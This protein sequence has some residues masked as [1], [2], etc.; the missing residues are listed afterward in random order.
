MNCLVSGAVQPWEQAE[1]AVHCLADAASHPVVDRDFLAKRLSLI[2]QAWD[3]THFPHHCQLK[4]TV[5]TRLA[6]VARSGKVTLSDSFLAKIRAAAAQT[7]HRNLQ[8]EALNFLDFLETL[9]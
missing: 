1:G 2:E 6:D 8:A 7:E 4:A 5:C 9:K 3:L